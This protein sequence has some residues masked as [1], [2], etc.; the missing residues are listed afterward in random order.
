[1]PSALT[2]FEQTPVTGLQVPS[3]W[4]GSATGQTTG[5]P[6]VHAPAWHASA[7]VQALPSSQVVPSAWLGLEQIPVAGLQVPAVWHWSGEGQT[8]ALDPVQAPAWHVS[9]WV[10]RFPSLQVVP[11]A[12]AGFEQIPVAGLQVPGVWHW[13]GEGQP[14][15]EPVQLPD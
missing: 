11:S 8:A 6:P 14:M 2:G 5:L 9:V 1:V 3:S 12:W 4:H 15:A 10:Q 7:W 13:S